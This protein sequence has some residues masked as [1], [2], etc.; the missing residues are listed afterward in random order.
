MSTLYLAKTQ[1]KK[2]N[3]TKDRETKCQNNCSFRE[4]NL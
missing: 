3:K 4:W 1:E 2:Q